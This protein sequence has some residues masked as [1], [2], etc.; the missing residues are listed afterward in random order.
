MDQLPHVVRSNATG[1]A[2]A[3]FG[4]YTDAVHYAEALETREGPHSP[5]YYVESWKR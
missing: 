3:T 2:V 4:I 5:G 1:N